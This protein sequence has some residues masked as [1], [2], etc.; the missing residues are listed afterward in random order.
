M[1]HFVRLTILGAMIAGAS[2]YGLA[3]DDDLDALLGGLADESAIEQA[4][5]PEKAAA[6]AADADPAVEPAVEEPKAEDVAAEEPSAEEDTPAV[7][8]PA[9]EE[10][11]AEESKAEEIAEDESA[12]PAPEADTPAVEEPVAEEE[13]AT[14]TP[15]ADTPAEE[16]PAVAGSDESA[17]L[18]GDAKVE[19]VL[20]EDERMQNELD[21][22]ELLR[23]KGLDIHAYACLDTAR[24]LMTTP[25][26][27]GKAF[28]QYKEAIKMY[29]DAQR[30]FRQRDEN[31]PAQDECRKGIREAKYRQATALFGDGNNKDALGRVP[32]DHDFAAQLV[33]EIEEAMNKPIE[34]VPEPKLPTYATDEYKAL[35][36]E[37]NDRMKR[38][39]TYFHVGNYDA[40]RQQI[41]LILR[42]D[43]DNESAINLRARIGRWTA[44]RSN[45]LKLA[46]H[47][48]LIDQVNKNWTPRGH[49][50]ADSEELYA[51]KVSTSGQRPVVDG[52]KVEEQKILAK[53]NYIRLPEFSIRPP[54][55]LADAVDL[56]S[57]MAK[58]Y[59][60]PE[61]APE[62]KGVSFVLSMGNAKPAATEESADPFATPGATASGLPPIQ[63]ISMNWVTLKEA[64]DM[65]CEVTGSKYVVKNK[66]VMIV[67]ANYVD[68]KMETRSYNVMSSFVEKVGQMSGEIASGSSA[69]D[70]WS[71]TST[72]EASTG[73][74]SD[75]ESWKK[76][77]TDLG[78]S[79]EGKASIVYLPSIGK[80]RVTNTPENLA[81]FENIL[82]ELNVTPYQIEVEARFVEVSQN[83]LNSLGFEWQLNQ[84]ISGTVGS[85]IDWTSQK[86]LGNTHG[87]ESAGG[88]GAGGRP[89]FRNGATGGTGSDN[90]VIH[91]GALNQGMRFLGDGAADASRINLGNSA[92][93]PNDQ[94]ATFSAVFGKV[95]MTMILHMLAQRTD[96]DMLSSP[97]VL[98]RPGQEA[99]IRVVTEWIYPTEFDVTELEEA[100]T[101]NDN[102]NAVIGG[103][104]IQVT[105]PPVKFA[106]EPQSFEKTD[107]GVTLQVVPE[108]S[109]EGQM[110]NLLV[111]PKVVEYLGDFEYGMK[112][113]Y[114]DYSVGLLG[115]TGAQ[116][117][118]YQVSMPQPKFHYREISTYLSVYNGSTVVMGGL[119]T[120][121]RN[122]FEDKV[123]ILG[124]LPFVG[125]LFRSK[126][127]FSEK[128][129]LLIFLT[130]RLVDPAG[131]P[132]KTATDGR[133][134]T[135]AI[136]AGTESSTTMGATAATPTAN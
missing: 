110:I 113:P 108:V 101:N 54:S 14:P 60:K 58:T 35:R 59:D 89:V 50:G 47:D 74:T 6:P 128:R 33:K 119:I 16:K 11:V 91:G 133:T 10:P 81:L 27:A 131:R 5:T 117:A 34:I 102:N 122:S 39:T 88:I 68:G 77:F 115:V 15:E 7:D 82:E 61:L 78:V 125:F 62:D 109:Q 100:D 55:T 52:G 49:L 83:D 107:V 26:P 65:V 21:T 75:S 132:L 70:A 94:F 118:Y 25:P 1:T 3:Q 104:G 90:V 69:S 99:L 106:V 20:G 127:E 98:A 111:N 56:F 4:D 96:T 84:D 37:I 30:F 130:A 43:P 66:T 95:D 71:T 134:G 114:V 116:I 44:A 93:A 51:P 76:L 45:E 121:K 86:I 73:G 87:G 72:T 105:P 42:A 85:G 31:I 53:L 80:L 38:A 32:K 40:A 41:E 29:S 126:G 13:P 18:I 112:V 97:K 36:V 135:A 120:E 124:D 129:N 19:D 17:P 67:P 92:L 63:N 23:Q 8:E 9:A 46:T 123:P 57:N 24:K 12:T 136:D 48:V 2:V 103:G 64:L 28:D 79:F 22:L